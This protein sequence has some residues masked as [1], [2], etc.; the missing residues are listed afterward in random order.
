MSGEKIPVRERKNAVEGALIA[1]ETAK[2]KTVKTILDNAGIFVGVFLLF[3][4][5]VVTTTD[6]SVQT[7]AETA[8]LG[9][10]FFV[11]LFCSYGMYINMTDSG[12]KQGLATTIYKEACERYEG[13]KNRIISGGYQVALAAFCKSYVAEELKSARTSILAN[14]GISYEEYEERLIG[15]DLNSLEEPLTEAQKKAVRLANKL[16]PVKLTSDMILKR[17]RGSA[18]RSPL[19]INPGEKKAFVFGGKFATTALTSILM[20]YIALDVITEPS[21]GM[22]ASVMLKMLAVVLNG[23]SGYQFGYEH[24]VG[25][26]VNFMNDQ[27]DLME[28]ALRS[29][30]IK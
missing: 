18:R 13:L 17:G 27:S 22:F 24:I 12:R 21:W 3:V 6:V 29:F 20:G 26:T 30:E 2:K 11:L 5:A 19:S 28:Q 9:L 1:V 25:D 16:K 8:A 4:V 23:F 7:A 10:E 15:K 14:V